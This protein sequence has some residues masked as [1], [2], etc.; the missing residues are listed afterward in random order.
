MLGAGRR[1]ATTVACAVHATVE[2]SVGRD[3]D[4]RS[5]RMIPV[6][7]RRVAAVC[8]VGPGRS[9]GLAQVRFPRSVVTFVDKLVDAVSL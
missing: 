9:A 5:R 1:Q 3:V 4:G 8:R 2:Q 6:A 7:R